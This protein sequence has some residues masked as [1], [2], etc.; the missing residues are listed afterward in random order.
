MTSKKNRLRVIPLGGLDGIGKNMTVL[1]LGNDMIV[2]DAGLMFPDDDHPGIDLILPD[3]SYIVQ[4]KDKLRGIIITHGHEDHTGALPYLLKDLGAPVPVLGTKLTLGI[5]A[6]KLEEHRIKKP[7]LRE[8][9]PGG[10]V[11][12]G[13]FGLDFFAVNHSI[14]DGVAV[15]VRT[16][17]GTVLHTGDFKLDQTPIDGRFTDFAGFARAAKQGVTLLLSDSTGAENPG[18]TPSEAVVGS[19]LRSIFASAQQRIIVASFA[20][21]VHRVQQICDAAVACGRKVVVT[22]RSMVNITRIARD[23][24]YL[25]IADDDIVDAYA[26][27]NLPADQVVVLCTGSQGEP[28]SALARIANGD[29]RTV[30]LEE[31]DTVVISASPVPGNEKAVS[32]VMNRLYH[33]GANV[34]HKG[35]ARVHVSGHASAEELKLMLNLVKPEY[36]MPVHGEIRHLHAHRELAKSVGIP[37]ENVFLLDNGDCLEMDESGVQRGKPVES[38]V[39]Y[40]DGLTVGD[41]GQ[42]VLRDRQ[43]LSSDGLAMIVVAI[44][45]RKGAV[46]GAPEV[47]TRGLVLGSDTE[48]ALKGIRTRVDKVLKRTA[49]EGV[50]DPAVIRKALHDAVSQ[51]VWET[52]KRRPMIIPTVMEV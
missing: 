12:L 37:E 17:A 38:G 32:R 13:M 18:H 48:A 2:I 10:H 49:A 36:M 40:V 21:H 41:L 35:M 51:Y 39:V 15:Y 16:P 26:M 8:I 19:S 44:D 29:H 46:V 47:I 5:I 3:Y 43:L 23:L 28:L 11:N 42:V 30:K 4:R 27:G 20:S 9:K 31:G 7:K 1:E 45:T 22:G 52:A 50:T 25:H 34:V 6:G 33:A 24:G 14:P